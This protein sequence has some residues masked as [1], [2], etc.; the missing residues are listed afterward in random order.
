MKTTDEL[1]H[2]NCTGHL[3]LQLHQSDLVV[4]KRRLQQYGR[5]SRGHGGTSPPEFRVGDANANCPPQILSYKYKKE[6]SVAC[7]IR[8]NPFSAEAPPRTPLGELTTLPRPPSRLGRGTPSHTSPHSAP[9]H[10][11]RSPCV[12]PE[13]QPALGYTPMHVQIHIHP[14]GTRFFFRNSPNLAVDNSKHTWIF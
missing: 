11:R 13:F 2:G 14:W 6:R 5:R 8:Q 7:K 12:S 3:L 10:L 4:L 9:T 1:L